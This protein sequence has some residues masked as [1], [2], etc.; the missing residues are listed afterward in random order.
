VAATDNGRL[1]ADKLMSM[2]AQIQPESDF[3]H[4][5]LTG[6][7]SL[8]EAKRTFLEILDAVALQKSKGILID[9]RTLAGEPRVIER[10]YYGSFAAEMVMSYQGRGVAAGTPFAY[11]L[12][13]P[14]LDSKR[15]GETVAVNRGMIVKA[16]DNLEEAL[17]WLSE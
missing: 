5:V 14:V 15:F 10:F 1:T 8:E 2:L 4:A 9:G 16:F 6:T 7:F 12:K 3:L 11:V 17:K 13:E